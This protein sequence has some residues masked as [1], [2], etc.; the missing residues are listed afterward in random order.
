MSWL[1]TTLDL[2]AQQP[3]CGYE[4]SA[5]PASEPTALAA[6]AL[7]AGWR[8]TSAKPALVWLAG[9]QAA[10]GSVGIRAGEGPGW[11][12]SLAV[13]AWHAAKAG[14]TY[15]R[16]VARAVAWILA[17][18][19][20]TSPRSAEYGHDPEVPGWSFA[21]KTSCWI[22]PTAL[23][24]TA[25]KAV[26]QAQHARTRDGVRLLVDRLLPGG[27]CNYGNTV[28]LGQML[29]PHVQPTGVA[30][31]ALRG[32]KDTSGRIARSVDWLRRTIGSETTPV[33]LAWAILGLH[34]QG[35][36]P[37]AAVE[38]L[39]AAADRVTKSGNSP[40]KLALLA[41]AAKGWP[42]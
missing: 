19:G 2:L 24:V 30:L 23:H 21:E 25:L 26:G 11:P 42:A 20:E 5:A 18:R 36:M 1:D 22:E 17:A 32:E 16:Q 41:L 3:V 40:H 14:P 33:S 31:L 12:T 9:I 37:A 27:G 38:W 35:A 7:V 4:R 34:A 15:E 6:L 28:V 10:D 29:R 13:L 39:A 8:S